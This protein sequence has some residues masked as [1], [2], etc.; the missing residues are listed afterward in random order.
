M[1]DWLVWAVCLAGGTGALVRHLASGRGG[2]SAARR[3]LLPP[4]LAVNVTAAFLAGLAAGAWSGPWAPV[5]VAGFCGGL[6]SWSALAADAER[7]VGEAGAGRTALGLA[8]Q[9][10]CGA[11]AAGTG[12]ALADA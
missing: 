6:G 12:L 5:L 4:S 3:A 1:S 11:V 2:G 9:L 8:V 7:S 10:A